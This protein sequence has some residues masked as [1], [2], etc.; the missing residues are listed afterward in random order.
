MPEPEEER[1]PGQEPEQEEPGGAM[2]FM[3]HLDELRTRLVHTA[4]GLIIA[5]AAA[6]AFKEH[7]YAF[8]TTPLLESSQQGVEL[9]YLDPT[10]AFFTYIKVSFLA[11]LVVASPWVFYQIWKFVAPG[12]YQKERRMVWPFVISASALFIGGSMFCFTTVFPW[13]FTFLRS[14][15]T[16]PQDKTPLPPDRPAIVEMVRGEIDQRL[17]ALG[18]GEV[19]AAM[20]PAQRDQVARRI[21]DQVLNRLLEALTQERTKP[22][23][24]TIKAQFTMRAYLSFTALLLIAFGVIFETPLV[25]VFLGRVGI[26][27]SAGLRKKRKYAILGMFVVAAILTPP[28]VVTQVL[29]AVPLVALYEISIWLVRAS[30]KKRAERE[31]EFE[32]DLESEE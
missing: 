25:L 32:E 14:F 19:V 13:A 3:A 26:V 30:E 23:Q 8:L 12:L 20:P 9:I 10:E 21:E 11:G 31:K 16:Q 2:P 18:G 1:K 4:Y 6:Y 27:S 28:D 24:L 17:K 22:G 15:E 7:I 5:F 29:M